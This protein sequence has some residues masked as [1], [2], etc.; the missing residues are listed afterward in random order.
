MLIGRK[1]GG[2]EEEAPAAE[3]GENAD[4]GTADMSWTAKDSAAAAVAMAPEV[5]S[6][7]A[8]APR[9]TAAAGRQLGAICHF[10][11]EQDPE[12]PTP[13]LILR[14]Y[15]WGKL[16]YYAP[17]LNHDALEAPPSDVRVKLKKATA[18]GD[19]DR[20]LEMTEAAMIEPYGRAWLDLQRYAVNALEQKGFSAAAKAISNGLRVLLEMLPDVASATLPDDTPTANAETRS[21]IETVIPRPAEMPDTGDSSS[22][23]SQED[24]SNTDTTTDPIS[25]PEPQTL[26]TE[27]NPPIL[28]DEEPPPSEMSD[29]FSAALQAIQFGKTE[30]GLGMITSLLATE[31]SGRAR[32][33]RR[34]QLAHLLIAAGKGKVAQPILDQLSTEIEQRRLEDWEENEALAYPLELLLRCLD[35]S[36]EERRAALYARIC[37][38]DPVRGVNCAL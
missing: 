34:T 19:F 25:E 38:L 21:W 15:A 18:E 35:H 17:M 28:S 12:D 32:F 16:E 37:K 26:E 27:S 24:Y 31:R 3:I 7:S 20:V 6:V 8:G 10:L 9:D 13:Y 22:G 4:A 1:P 33:R 5:E 23:E 11:R 2:N 30:T 29:E 14:S 36:D